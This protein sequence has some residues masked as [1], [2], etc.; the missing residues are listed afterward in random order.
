MMNKPFARA[1]ALV[2]LTTVA[3]GGCSMLDTVGGWFS[4]GPS[5]SKLKG[6]RISVMANAESIT[7][8]SELKDV[9]V[10]LPPPYKN[11]AWP[12]PGGY[13]TNAMYHLEASGPLREVWKAD[14]GKGSDDDSRLTAPPVVADGKVF[15][16]D[17]KAHASAFAVAGG[18]RV[19]A[20]S[21]AEEGETSILHMLTLGAV[22]QDTTIDPTKGF[23]G[24]LAYDNGV[25][26]VTTGFGDVFALNAAN[27]KRI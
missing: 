9:K 8:D 15:V 23:G 20:E 6:E 25:I 5:K 3:L 27:G 19:W 7:P 2:V 14:A 26:Y 17:S 1:M 18:Q 10:V 13:P 16:L 12:Q 11:P 24:G 4:G 21:L 22:G